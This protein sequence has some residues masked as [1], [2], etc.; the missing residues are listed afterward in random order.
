MLHEPFT[1][2]SGKRVRGHGH[3]LIH[4]CLID[5]GGFRERLP[6]SARECGAGTVRVSP[7]GT[8][9]SL[10]VWDGGAA[11]DILELPAALTSGLAAPVA[12]SAYL[13]PDAIASPRDRLRIAAAGDDAFA[14]ECA[15]L[16]L[17]ARSLHATVRPDPPRWLRDLR[18]DLDDAPPASPSLRACARRHE[19]HASHTARAFRAWFGRSLGAHLRARRLPVRHG[20]RPCPCGTEGRGARRLEACVRRGIRG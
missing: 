18:A 13:H 10:D 15:A 19:R 2:P 20:L 3:A 4:V 11:G 5:S 17:V 9:H 12:A 1:L 16:E 6:T 8:A 14:I 7:G